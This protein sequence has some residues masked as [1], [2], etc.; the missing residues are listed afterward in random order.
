MRHGLDLVEL[1]ADSHHRRAARVSKS[2]NRLAGSDATGGILKQLEELRA[3]FYAGRRS[4]AC[5][6]VVNDSV[7][8][9]ARD[10]AGAAVISIEGTEPEP[11]FLVGGAGLR[12][13]GSPL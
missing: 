13:V 1:F 12:W 10:N 3:D 9:I 11:T 4:A 8:I 2:S 5:P 6:L 7:G